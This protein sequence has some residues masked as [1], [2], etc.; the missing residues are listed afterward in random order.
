MNPAT[1]LTN[2][3][4][5]LGAASMPTE[6]LIQI[7]LC[8]RVDN[9]ECRRAAAALLLSPNARV[10]ALL[11]LSRGP[12]LLAALELGRRALLWPSPRGQQ[13]RGP[14]DVAALA[15]PRCQAGEEVLLAFALDARLAV[16]RVLEVARGHVDEV[17]ARP[18]DVL[19]PVLA[20]G[21]RHLAL[22]HRHL[23]GDPTPSRDDERCTLRLLDCA[24]ELGMVL[25]DHVVLGDEGHTSMRRIGLLPAA[26]LRYR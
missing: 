10:E 16:T 4:I 21:C 14:S 25:L 23:S 22:A 9:E 20:T 17:V 1:H 6:G 13:I 19:G 26:D 15:A 3:L 2:D 8:G 5:A 11:D 24:R 12:Q 18:A 7:L